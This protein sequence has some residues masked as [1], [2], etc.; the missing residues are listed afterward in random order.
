MES[1]NLLPPTFESDHGRN[2]FTTRLLLHHFLGAEDLKWLSGFDAFGLSE[3][4]KRGLILVK[5]M[6][7]VDN[8]TYRQ[9]NNIETLRASAELRD[10]NKKDLLSPKGKGRA[11]YYVPGKNLSTPPPDLSTPPK[12]LSA[13]PQDLSA[14]VPSQV[15]EQLLDRIKQLGARVNDESLIKGILIDLCKQTYFKASEIAKLLSKR[16][17]YIKR[18]YLSPMIESGELIYRFPEMINHPEQAYKTSKQNQS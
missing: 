5:E 7:A 2:T 10:L 9:T 12:D 16:E 13:P 11:T 3:N 6:G 8:S 15:P 17:D 14:P 4:Q 1:A 18:K